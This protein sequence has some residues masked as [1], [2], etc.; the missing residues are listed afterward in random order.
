MFCFIFIHFIILSIYQKGYL[1]PSRFSFF[2]SQSSKIFPSLTL[3]FFFIFFLPL[4]SF[5]SLLSKVCIRKV[6]KTFKL[7]FVAKSSCS[8]KIHIIILIYFSFIDQEIT[9]ALQPC[10]PPCL[11]VLN[12]LQIFFFLFSLVFKSVTSPRF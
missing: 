1:S 10:Y 3:T 5:L 2:N 4:H 9:G 6:T 8:L 12:P 7:L 11:V